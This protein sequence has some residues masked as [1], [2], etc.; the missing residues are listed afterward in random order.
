MSS[1]AEQVDK[2]MSWCSIAGKR[3]HGQ[4][5]SYQRKYLIGGLLAI[6]EG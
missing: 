5:N 4:G 6:S 2:T 1:A 3:H